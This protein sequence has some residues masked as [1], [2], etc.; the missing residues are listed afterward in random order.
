MAREVEG[1]LSMVFH[2]YLAGEVRGRPALRLTVNG[3]NIRAWDPYAR[4]EPATKV[5]A[6]VK[7][8]I[9]QGGMR[10]HLKIEPF[11]LPHQA[12]FSSAERFR[13]AS[14]PANWNQQ[15]GFYIYRAD[16]LIQC[17]GWSR[18][19]TLDEHTKLARI[20]L[21]FSPQLDNAFRVNV[22]KMRVHLPSV[23]RDQIAAIVAPVAKIANDAYRRTESKLASGG[24]VLHGGRTKPWG[25]ASIQTNRTIAQLMAAATQEEQRVI[26]RV[27]ARLGR[28]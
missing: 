10:G 5:L 8:A 6:P 1:H 21:N 27:V 17:G 4:D 25:P 23:A 7:I 11:V 12:D 20:A 24:I 19:R 18:I 28:R 16:R 22:A 14:G 13:Y 9:T 2:R 26:R 15:Q 3:A